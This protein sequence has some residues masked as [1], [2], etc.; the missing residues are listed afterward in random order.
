[1]LKLGEFSPDEVRWGKA[2]A[3][4]LECADGCVDL[5]AGFER[6]DRPRGASAQVLAV[7]TARTLLCFQRNQEEGFWRSVELQQSYF[8][9]SLTDHGCGANGMCPLNATAILPGRGTACR[10]SEDE[11]GLLEA[12]GH[13][14]T[15]F[16]GWVVDANDVGVGI[17]V[18]GWVLRSQRATG[19]L[20][21]KVGG[22]N[23]FAERVVWIGLGKAVG[24]RIKASDCAGIGRDD[25]EAVA[26]AS[27][28]V[29]GGGRKRREKGKCSADYE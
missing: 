22:L 10:P 2:G 17:V 5:A 7:R 11:R 14:D 21:E 26:I 25:G 19:D 16:A 15:L 1:M 24:M 29:R 9:G 23:A 20:L 4:A 27:D 12:E 3:P 13:E 28:E 18:S 6:E 8:D